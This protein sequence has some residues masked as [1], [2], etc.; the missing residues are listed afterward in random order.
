M[1]PEQLEAEKEGAR[2]AIRR[3]AIAIAERQRLSLAEGY[4]V[5]HALADEEMNLLSLQGEA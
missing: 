2:S 3:L 4:G 5:I 1:T